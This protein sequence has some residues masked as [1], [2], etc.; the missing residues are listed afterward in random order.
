MSVAEIEKTKSD[1]I[2][3]IEHLSDIN[4]L[5]VLDGLRV[6]DRIGGII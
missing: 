3:W 6:S 5:S 1:L 2:T 4:M